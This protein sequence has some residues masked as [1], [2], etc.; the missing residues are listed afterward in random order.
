ME[1]TIKR[2]FWCWQSAYQLVLKFKIPS[3]CLQGRDIGLHHP[4]FLNIIYQKCKTKEYPLKS[5]NFKQNQYDTLHT[6]IFKFVSRFFNLHLCNQVTEFDI[7]WYIVGSQTSMQWIVFS[8]CGSLGT[9]S[10]INMNVPPISASRGQILIILGRSVRHQVHQI[11]SQLYKIWGTYSVASV[12]HPST[13]EAKCP[14]S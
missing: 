11:A 2:N 7:A 12:M 5:K 8:V 3:I 14:I 1:L 4:F 6:K 13:V 10:V 9:Y